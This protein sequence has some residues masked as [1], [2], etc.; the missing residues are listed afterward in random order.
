MNNPSK[1]SFDHYQTADHLF[2]I[3]FPVAKDPKLL[4]LIVK[5]LSNCLE[6]T[7]ETILTKEKITT[8]EG[9]LKKINTLRPL[10]AK[11]H[12]SNDDIVFMLRIQEILY[13]QKQSPMEFKRGNAQVIC[14][15]DYD[16]EVVS[17]KDVEEFLHNTNK[18]INIVNKP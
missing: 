18:I 4:L 8:P 14:S 9:L 5:S 6:Y 7:I 15:N 12:L 11:Y 1:K 2:H 16:L 10:A 17:A 3:T 13:H